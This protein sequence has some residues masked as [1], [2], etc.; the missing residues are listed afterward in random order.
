MW[1]P[2][3]SP[4]AGWLA[5]SAP[6]SAPGVAHLRLTL[7]MPWP[8]GP[9]AKWNVRRAPPTAP[10]LFHQPSRCGTRAA[11]APPSGAARLCWYLCLRY[12]SP[13]IKTAKKDIQANGTAHWAPTLIFAAFRRRGEDELSTPLPTFFLAPRGKYQLERRCSIR[14]NPICAEDKGNLPQKMRERGREDP[15]LPGRMRKPSTPTA[16]HGTRLVGRKCK[17]LKADRKKKTYRA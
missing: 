5:S 12:G 17:K 9:T 16:P 10:L 3:P 15:C 2:F 6:G 4:A 1:L 7:L 13:R 11:S 8:I 14:N